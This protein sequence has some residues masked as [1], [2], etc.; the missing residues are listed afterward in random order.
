MIRKLVLGSI[1]WLAFYLPAAQGGFV[2]YGIV[3][4]VSSDS[5]AGAPMHDDTL[6]GGWGIA[7][8]PAERGTGGHFWLSSFGNGTSNQYVGDVGAVPLFQDALVNMDAPPFPTG[9]VPPN[10]SGPES[11]IPDGAGT[12]RMTGQTWQQTAGFVTSLPHLNGVIT[13][14]A[15]FLFATEDGVI[16]AWTDNKQPDGTAN[17]VG[18]SVA[19]IDRSAEGSRFY[20]ITVSNASGELYTADR[21]ATPGVKV[22][23]ADFVEVA[24]ALDAFNPFAGA[25]GVQPGEFAALNVQT[26]RINGDGNLFV[27][28]SQAAADTSNPAEIAPGIGTVGVGLGRV[29]EYTPAGELVAVWDDRGLLNAPYGLAFSPHD[30]GLASDMLLVGNAGDGSIVAFDPDTRTA[31]DYLRDAEGD[32]IHIDGLKGLIFG[33]G[34]SLGEANAL[35]FAAGP[36]GGSNGLFGKVVSVPEPS[37][38]TLGGVL[39]AMLQMGRGTRARR[40]LSI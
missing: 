16:S 15:K 1:A 39:L 30:F 19:E 14:P 4:L 23:G 10:P 17:W 21:G 38:L 26:A 33:N 20:G 37:T 27:T 28:Y 36:D 3:P 12:A 7:I 31:V 8:R 13:G 35:Y 32:V 24:T 40:S 18:Y 2:D 6:I 11:P 34:V 5:S 25:D 29:A 9:F 22:F